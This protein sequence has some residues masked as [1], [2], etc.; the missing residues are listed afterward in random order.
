VTFRNIE[1]TAGAFVT[2][3]SDVS[4]I[5]GSV[6]PGVNYSPEIKD[7]GGSSLPPR[8]ILFDGVIF[9]DWT[10]NDNS[11]HVDC[12]HVMAVDG[13]VL[14]NSRFRNCEIF[15][16]L[17]T[18]FGTTGSPRNV[19]VENNF[20]SCCRSGYYSLLLA[21][22]HGE[23]W[24]NF[25]IRNNST[26]KPMSLGEG[27]TT[28]R[29]RVVFRGNIGPY[30][31]TLDCRAPGVSWDYNVW[32]SGGRCGAHDMIAPSDFTDAGRQDFHLR[33]GAAAVRRGDP[34]SHPPS[35]IDGEP[36]P[37][38]R[39]DAGADQLRQPRS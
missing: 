6:G 3:A 20:F 24:S 7:D 18:R 37:T 30:F 17:F 31:N 19:V 16:V 22:G 32:A 26:D 29:S 8:R 14:R 36:R 11:S 13:F 21:N 34:R 33:P 38:A 28:A 25:L 39:P 35:D 12:L 5:G 10:R 1:S 4:A 2:S 15:D 23:Q 27:S 9:H